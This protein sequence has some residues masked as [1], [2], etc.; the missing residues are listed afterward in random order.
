MTNCQKILAILKEAGE[1]GIH[2]FDLIKRS[3]QYRA[4]ARINDLKKE[5]F[6]IISLSEKRGDAHGCRY[7]LVENLKTN[8]PQHECIT[9]RF[10]GNKAIPVV[11]KP[12]AEGRLF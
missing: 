7:F 4:A 5:G 8:P 11:V 2:S 12:F 1:T 6:N 9:W 10:E 3:G